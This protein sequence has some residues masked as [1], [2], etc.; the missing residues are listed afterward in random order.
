MTANKFRGDD[1]KVLISGVSGPMTVRVYHEQ[2]QP[3]ITN[4]CEQNVCSHLCLP[5]AHLR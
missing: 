4:K 5:R 3:N 1:V 2:A